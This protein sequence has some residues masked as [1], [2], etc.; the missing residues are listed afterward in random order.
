MWPSN[1]IRCD[2]LRSTWKSSSSKWLSSLR[3]Q[4]RIRDFT[5]KIDRWAKHWLK[6]IIMI[7]NLNKVV[8]MF[9][10]AKKAYLAQPTASQEAQVSSWYQKHQNVLNFIPKKHLHAQRPHSF[11]TVKH[12]CDLILG[13]YHH[14]VGNYERMFA[15]QKLIF[16]CEASKDNCYKK[17]TDRVKFLMV[18]IS[19]WTMGYTVF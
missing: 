19:K 7:E 4:I 9:F 14:G 10:N 6:R 15:D 18:L 12:D 1:R 16:S 3:F 5:D 2:K 17:F 8:R 11:W 13:C